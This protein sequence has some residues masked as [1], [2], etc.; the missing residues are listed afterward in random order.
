MCMLGIEAHTW[1]TKMTSNRLLGSVSLVELIQTVFKYKHGIYRDS[2]AL[3]RANPEVSLFVLRFLSLATLPRPCWKNDLSLLGT[4]QRFTIC[5]RRDV[6]YPVRA[7]LR[8]NLRW[9]AMLASSIAMAAMLAWL[10]AGGGSW[11]IS[12]CVPLCM[13]TRFINA[14]QIRP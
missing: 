11:W 9:D 7:D 1:A 3:A 14:R 13:R 2:R 10:H 12:S 6:P 8:T 4:P 5:F